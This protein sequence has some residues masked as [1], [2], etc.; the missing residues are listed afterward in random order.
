MKNCGVARPIRL[1][2][3]ERLVEQR[4][5]AAG[6]RSRR[7]GSTTKKAMLIPAIDQLQR[8][9]EEAHHDVERRL[10]A[11]VG[12]LPEVEAHGVGGERPELGEDR[13]VEAET[14]AQLVALLLGG[15]Q[16]QDEVDRVA[17]Q[18]RD[19]EHEHADTDDHDG[20]LGQ[21]CGQSTSPLNV[22]SLGVPMDVQVTVASCEHPSVGP[23]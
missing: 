17:D 14:G 20:P 18:P 19:D 2:R 15:R 8:L 22:L 23:P 11:E 4:A 6:R 10:V 1:K 21:P 16:R 7:A 9:G 3:D 13:L 5:R 12:G